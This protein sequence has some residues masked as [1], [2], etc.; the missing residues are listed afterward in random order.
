MQKIACYIDG[1]NLYHSID[2]LNRPSLKWVNLFSLADSLTRDHEKLISVN[3]FSAF[4][5]WRPDQYRRHRKYIK[6]LELVGVTVTMAH[7][8]KKDRTCLKCGVNWVDHEEKETDVRLALKMLED[9]EDNIFDRAILISAD[10]DLV[11]VIQTIKKR[12]PKKTILVATPPNRYSTGRDLRQNA[13]SSVEITPGR[14]AK[15]LL[16]D[17]LQDENG[18]QIVLRPQRYDPPVSS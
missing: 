17:E 16:P 6:A 7:F 8:K 2:D 5:T 9:C 15:H 3:Y 12:S 13:H 18:K 11:P 10:S 14:I 1:F 4:A